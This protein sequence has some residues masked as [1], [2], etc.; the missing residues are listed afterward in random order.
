MHVN[1]ELTL[2]ENIA[3]IGGLKIAYV[4]LQKSLAGKPQPEK[5]DGLTADQRFFLAFAQGWRR[6]ATPGVAPRHD[7]HRPAFALGVP[8]ARTGCGHAGV[9]AGVCLRQGSRGSERGDLVRGGRALVGSA[10]MRA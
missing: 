5:I 4:A 1:G 9:R 2:G 6:N 7:R 10:P 3:D 8:G